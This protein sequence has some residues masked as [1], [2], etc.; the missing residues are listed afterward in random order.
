MI[1]PQLVIVIIAT[2]TAAACADVTGVDAETGDA[3]VT[4]TGNVPADEKREIAL[5]LPK[6]AD[7]PKR[8]EVITYPNPDSGAKES[9]SIDSA[10]PHTYLKVRGKWYEAFAGDAPADRLELK[11]G[12]YTVEAKA[13]D[14]KDVEFEVDIA[15]GTIYEIT[16]DPVKER[17][18]D[19][20]HLAITGVIVGGIALVVIL[21]LR[22]GFSFI[23]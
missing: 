1:K 19:W 2:L 5:E 3:L 16:I 14:Y 13:D 21:A 6:N 22:I 20:E 18:T 23:G 4:V 8:Y 17:F 15:A 10:A 7:N 9:V 11:P 12:I